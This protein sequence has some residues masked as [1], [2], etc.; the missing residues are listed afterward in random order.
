[1]VDNNSDYVIIV[2]IVIIKPVELSNVVVSTLHLSFNLLRQ[3]VTKV[4]GDFVNIRKNFK[5]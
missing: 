1:L 3:I 4:G 5:I 2:T